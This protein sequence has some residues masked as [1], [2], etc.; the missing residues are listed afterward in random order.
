MTPLFKDG[1][2]ADQG[3]R[4]NPLLRKKTKRN[5]LFDHL[6]G[7]VSSALSFL[8]LDTLY[9]ELNNTEEISE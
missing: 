8:H 3:R 6:L 4:R 1:G 7:S 9:E 2:K 5:K